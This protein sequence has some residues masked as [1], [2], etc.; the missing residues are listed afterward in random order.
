M[1]WGYTNLSRHLGEDQPVYGFRSRGTDG[2]AEF[3]SIEAMAAQYVA[4]LRVFQPKGPYYLGGYCFGGNVA[5]EM[6]RVLQ[7]QGE[8]V[9]LLA[10]INSGPPNSTY[11]EVRWSPGFAL[12]FCR[13]LIYWMRYATTWSAKQRKDFVRW[14]LSVM[15]KTIH[16]RLGMGNRESEVSN[17]V[18]LEAYPESERPLWEAHIRCLM[19][20][21]PKPYPGKVT[22]FRSP[23]HPF[24][25]SFDSRYGWGNLAMDGV[26]VHVVSGHHESILEEPYVKEVGAE[27]SRVLRRAQ[28][29]QEAPR[30]QPPPSSPASRTE[31]VS[32]PVRADAVPAPFAVAR[33]AQSEP[34]VEEASVSLALEPKEC[35]TPESSGQSNNR[36]SAPRLLTDRPLTNRRSWRAR[37]ETLALPRP[38]LD[39]LKRFSHR[40]AITL[41]LTFMAASGTLLYRHTRQD[42]FACPGARATV[43]WPVG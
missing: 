27:M 23:G 36:T 26:D 37:V 17:W 19:R 30:V 38:L 18:D 1:F 35:D 7:Q 16:H 14:K 8:E 24:L 42:S 12:K 28:T 11:T 29:L 40:E 20:Y 15:W 22:L 31:P 32:A 2:R 39:A 13:N 9:A 3:E 43:R 33:R 21:K 4:D 41:F 6:A 5:Y 10:L 34:G 25:C